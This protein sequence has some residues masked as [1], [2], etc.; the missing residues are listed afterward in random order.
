MPIFDLI[1]LDLNVNTDY[2]YAKFSREQLIE[3][4]KLLKS[5]NEEL[6]KARI[7]QSSSEKALL[8]SAGRLNVIL[9]AIPDM[10]FRFDKTNKLLDFHAPNTDLRFTPFQ[11][12][13]GKNIEE[14]FPKELTKKVLIHKE[15]ALLHKTVQVFEERMLSDDNLYYE[16]IRVTIG[17]NFEYFTIF[18]D[19]SKRK[20]IEIENEKYI[21]KI[22]E[23]KVQLEEW[24]VE[25][26]MLNYK[27]MESKEELAKLNKSKD[28]FFSIVAHDLKN[29]LFSLLGLLEILV[30]RTENNT[31]DETKQI[32]ESM[33]RSAKS[34]YALLEN[35]LQWSRVQTGKIEYSPV[36]ISLNSIFE[37][38]ASLYKI[39]AEN[40]KIN[41][42]YSDN[43]GIIVYADDNILSTVLRNLVSNAVKFTPEGGKIEISSRKK[44]RKAEICVSDTGVGIKPENIE[45]IFKI[46]A[47]VS[48]KGTNNEEGTGL[49][50]VLCKE[51]IELNKGELKVES[52][53]GKGTKFYFTI[54]LAE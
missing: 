31:D 11:K 21:E 46:D 4:I 27:L 42:S 54:P 34:L 50:L 17:D 13:V 45:K 1:F 47:Q 51:F 43:D 49:G 25:L 20:K 52:E 16:E 9:N 22:T 40:K 15:K 38:A 7:L 53:P 14:V 6:K 32:V 12:L 24:A 2:D 36:K 18:R 3:Q 35:L 37:I 33:N 30:E 48:T 29:P 8:D 44:N 41:L 19:I 26:K 28:K 5:E 23:S 10:I 39:P